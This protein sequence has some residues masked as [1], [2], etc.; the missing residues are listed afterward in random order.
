MGYLTVLHVRLGAKIGDLHAKD[1]NAF[2]KRL[3][4]I[5]FETNKSTVGGDLYGGLNVPNRQPLK[6]SRKIKARISA[7][8]HQKTWDFH[9]LYLFKFLYLVYK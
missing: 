1:S 3:I 7:F 4:L 2:R 6:I 9:H 5:H 8:P